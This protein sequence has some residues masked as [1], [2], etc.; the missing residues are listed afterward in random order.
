MLYVGDVESS[1]PQVIW[2]QVFIADVTTPEK[3]E[4]EGKDR[5]AGPRII[6]A[7]EAIPHPDPVHNRIVLDMRDFRSTERN[8]EGKVIT[9]VAPQQFQ[10][11]QA[12]T[13]EDLQVNRTVQEMD[14]GPLYKL[15]FHQHALARPDYVNAAIEFHERFSLPLACIL[16]AMVGI[17]LGVS[18]RK[19]G[20]S[21]A[22]I[23]TVLV[24]F[25]YYLA[26]ATLINMAKKGS[27]PVPVAVWT[28]DAVFA[29]NPAPFCCCVWNIQAT[30]ISSPGSRA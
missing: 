5:G 22:F 24:A 16:L 7:Q 8:K 10:V 19:G 17:P 28:P 14:T 15:V 25:L 27:L 20:K 23:L 6:I 12:Q 2:R 21:A 9:T 18:S 3:L 13:Q 30:A 4:Q 1:G 29:D 26:L 11:L